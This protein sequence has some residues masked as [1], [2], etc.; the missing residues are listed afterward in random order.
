MG[1][2]NKVKDNLKDKD[3]FKI[4][5]YCFLVSF[6][7]LIFTS[8]CSFLYPFNDWVD[9]N[10]FFTV[11]KSMMNGIVPYRDLFEQKGLL[12][13]FIYGVGYLISNT[14]FIGI[15]ILEIIFW[16]ISLYYVYK[17]VLLFLSIKS[18]YVIIPLFASI[19]TTSAAFTHGGG[20]EEFC[21]P[22]FMITMY[23]YLAHFKEKDISY[24]RLVIAGSLAG[25]ILLIKYTLLGFWFAFMATIFFSLIFK[26]NYKKAFLSCIYFLLGMMIPIITALIYLLCNGALLD[27][28]N[29]YFIINMTA[30]NN[31]AANIL[32]R[33]A[34]I[35]GGFVSSSFRNGILILLLLSLFPILVFFLKLKKS[36]K[37][38]LII[39]YFFTMLGVF[40]GLRFYDYYLFPMLSF[41]VISLISIF[42][43]LKKFIKI[44]GNNYVILGTL[45]IC[46]LNVYWFA[47]Y[48]EFRYTR[49]EDLF[50]YKFA[51]IIKNEEN[52][53]LVNMGFLDAGVYTTTG[54]I[55]TT[56][57]FE[58]QNISYNEYP[59][60]LDAFED[61]IE[62]QKTD[63]I[64]YY[65][66]YNLEKLK[67][68][69]TNL[70]DK[71]DLISSE[72]YLFENKN[73]NAYL[74]KKKEV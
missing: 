48:K 7:V 64:V 66:K 54:I 9:A 63:F 60:N 12:L 59:D 20:A 46:L 38:Y 40:F 13:Y 74:F 36:G 15:F 6:I 22:F 27:F 50:Q 23:Y 33:L 65:T 1:I 18:A 70:F 8:K 58:K 51:E 31:E 16:T 29:V 45:L 4:I 69:E 56:Y 34:S 53:T 52:P 3:K 72:E 10:A 49:K 37:V 47:N 19:I 30:Y 17:I 57:Y 28:I 26:K 35:Y 71:Y 42:T 55:P 62:K 2:W 5:L 61:Y 43:F 39:V 44:N 14:T 32:V 68:K 67:N 25:A 41:L 73:Y 11:G 21:L 24:K